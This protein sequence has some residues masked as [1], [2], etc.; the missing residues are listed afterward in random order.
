MHHTIEKNMKWLYI[1]LLELRDHLNLVLEYRHLQ[2]SPVLHFFFFL[3][4]KHYSLWLQ[5]MIKYC[6]NVFFFIFDCCINWQ[7]RF[8]KAWPKFKRITNAVNM[9]PKVLLSLKTLRSLESRN[10]YWVVERNHS[11][12]STMKITQKG[13]LTSIS[14]HWRTYFQNKRNK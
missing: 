7:H 14:G 12:T 8:L 5:I 6:K 9:K 3:Q 2:T 10:R 1:L 11:L 4:S 13:M